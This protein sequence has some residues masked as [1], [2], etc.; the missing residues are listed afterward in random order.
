MLYPAT[1]MFVV[2]YL[3]TRG[4]EC[5]LGR[6]G[7]SA[8]GYRFSFLGLKCGEHSGSTKSRIR[9]R[10]RTGDCMCTYSRT[11]EMLHLWIS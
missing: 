1:I 7:L 3:D 5:G 2:N 8:F 6:G 11:E 4:R 9:I 10:T